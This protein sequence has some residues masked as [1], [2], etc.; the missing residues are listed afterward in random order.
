[1]SILEAVNKDKGVRFF[2]YLLEL[3]N[4]VGKVVRDYKEYDKYWFIEEF[5]QLDGCYVLDECEEEEN[6]LEIHKPE[7]TSR[8][9]ESPKLDFVLNDWVK[10]EIHNEN[11][12]PEYK[13]EKVTLDSNGENVR[14]Y[15]EDDPERVKAFQNWRADWQKWAD[16]LKKKKKADL[17]YN[18]FFELIS[19][20]EKEGES[21]EFVF[22]KGI[23]TWAH[24]DKKVGTIRHPLLTCKLEVELDAEKGVVEAKQ[25]EDDIA[26]E[27]EMLSGVSLPNKEQVND[28]LKE[29]QALSMTDDMTQAFQ[30]YIHLIDANGR[31]AENGKLELRD[32]PILYNR[33][34]FA[35]RTKNVRVLRDDLEHIIEG[36]NS[37]E[38]EL[39]ESIL[40]I[41]DGNKER[42]QN[43]DGEAASHSALPKDHLYFPL[44]SNEQQKE[45]VNRVERNY[46]VTVQGPPG[47]GKTHTIANLVS[48]FLAQGKR[49]LITS[50]KENPLKVLKNKIPASIQD[51]C[52]PVLG[53]G[54]ESMEEIEKSI[55]TL[56]E[57]LGELDP[58]GLKNQIE[59]NLAAIDKSKRRTARLHNELET[60]SRKE[61][62]PID[63]KGEK[64]YKYEVAKR[65][66]EAEL[67]YQWIKD[68]V[69]LEKEFPLVQVDFRE[70][71]KLRGM[72][73][74]ADLPLQ[75]QK[76]PSLN[77]HI[78]SSRSFD[79]LIEEGDE[80]NTYED[81]GKS[82]LHKYDL[83]N[84]DDFIRRL[85]EDAVKVLEKE[86]LLT[87]DAYSYVMEDLMVGGV[88]EDRWRTFIK[89]Q[90]ENVDQLFAYYNQLI[91]HDVRLPDKNAAEL[92]ADIEIAKDRVKSGKKPN[93]LFFLFKGKRTKYL[94]Q[95]P[96]LNGKPIQNQEDIET[97][98]S[99]L[100]YTAQKKETARVINGNMDEIGHDTIDHVSSR[101]PHQADATVKTIASAV[102]LFDF[103]TAIQAKLTADQLELIDF[104][105]PETLKTLVQE[106]DVVS[107]YI[108]LE[109]WRKRQ[110]E[111]LQ[112]LQK[113]STEEN[114]HPIIYKFMEALENKDPAKWSQLI[115]QRIELANKQDHV[116]KF[117]RLVNKLGALLPATAISLES[118]VGTDW[119]FP[120]QYDE[121]FELRKLQTWL[122][123]TK[124]M[125]IAVMKDQLEE[126]YQE[127]KQLIREIVSASTWKTQME[128]ISEKE[129][130]ALSSW[131]TYIKRFG[132]GS[133]KYAHVHLEGARESMKTAQ[134]A[135]PVWIMPVNQVMENFPVTNDKFDVVIFDE[136]SQC[137]V[138]S[139]NLLLRGEKMI[140]VGD[141]EQIS[142]Q[143]IGTKQ[144]DVHELVHRYLPDI[145]NANLFDGNIS[146]YEMA[147]QT[148]P[149]EGKLM[150]REHFRCVPEIIQF[151]ND[152]SYGGEMI[153]LRL[154]VEDE[155]IDPPVTTTK[156]NDGYNDD[157]DKDINRPEA[158]KIVTDIA[159]MVRDPKYDGQT[160]GIIT[161]QGNTQQALLE[162]LIREEIGDEE[163]VRRK[164][165]CG[166]AYTLQGNE[167]DIIFLS[168]VVAS[169]RNFRALTKNSE[170]QRINVA[171][172][173]AK[174]QM[175]LYHSIDP[176][177]LNPVDLRYR[178]LSYCRQPSR[179]NEEVDNLEEQCDSPF[180]VDVLRMILAKGY[181]VTPQVKVGKYRIDLVVEGMRDRLAVECD[182]EKW[183]GPEKFDEDMRRQE[184]LER[185]GWKFWRIRGRE[186]YFN[187][188]KAMESLWTK[189]D[190]M[191]IE[192]FQDHRIMNSNMETQ[193]MINNP[194][195]SFNEYQS[196]ASNINSE[197]SESEK[198]LRLFEDDS[199]ELS[200]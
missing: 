85:K 149:K 86:D 118:S 69:D 53:G 22:G 45:I 105:Q 79:Q 147:E 34:M 155:K 58:A 37:D 176:E 141:E 132:K 161:L 158:E 102:E 122:D 4:L 47:T 76:L 184:S 1:M 63:Y 95:E 135:I 195:E 103:I 3:N 120:E 87:H 182:G 54:R 80:L 107:R 110:Q 194:D 125:N 169:N 28:V 32:Y 7:I 139:A 186:F 117:Y 124:D 14:E 163:F 23:L 183:H 62:T 43:I 21:L 89:E 46:G 174:N 15:F 153:P 113:V 101:F 96:V 121:M 167:R 177:E 200:K 71:W 196:I 192:P 61:G 111:E 51:L 148:F 30:Q 33:S 11:V 8:D 164:I 168:M 10:T 134:S 100:A 13:S 25:V 12:I 156:V 144:E 41:L 67:D 9:K 160:F 128:R 74:Q 104:Y 78:R 88:R 123:E 5:A 99:Y 81:E 35:L 130:R 112:F 157:K 72:L 143:A 154:P 16:N 55:R 2:K 166:N 97:V 56:S 29:I 66:A 6:Y 84:D 190:D 127:Q 36:V 178:L 140:V 64:L 129:K 126:E 94:F 187:R 189:L 70:L 115:D 191:G 108:A 152:L 92:E 59:R 159:E 146:L 82:I 150:L 193:T 91:T 60:Y 109:K 20:F 199:V 171:A 173:R 38:I 90:Q 131:K 170:K 162:H 44:A 50:Q 142:P 18:N 49:I 48:H 83:M 75:Q 27:N 145:P 138:F 17:L 133:G 175:R 119:E 172:S 68:D 39:S 40:S 93:I 114:M 31:Y 181:K 42:E 106:L 151:S 136:S 165:I 116:I 24:P 185:A 179:L 198:Q 52:V 188:T 65:L 19:R 137:D 73:N 77:D 197:S 57:K 180:E 98:E 26:I